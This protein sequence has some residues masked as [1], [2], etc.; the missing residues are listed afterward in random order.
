MIVC[1]GLPKT[2]TSSFSAAMRELGYT[3]P[4]NRGPRDKW[5]EGREFVKDLH[6]YDFCQDAP[7]CFAVDEIAKE[8][9]VSVVLTVRKSPD[10]WIRSITRKYWR[11]HEREMVS[12]SM[13]HLFCNEGTIKPDLELERMYLSHNE[14]VRSLGLP[15]IEVCWEKGDGFP[16]LCEFLRIPVKDKRFPHVNKSR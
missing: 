7:W 12:R 14:W 1:G 9:P 4:D 16:E 2:G 11:N 8:H 10:K 6:G 5:L 15:M 13:R 3:E